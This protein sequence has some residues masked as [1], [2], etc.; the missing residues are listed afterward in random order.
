MNVRMKT[1]YELVVA[2]FGP[3]AIALAAAIEDAILEGRLPASFRKKVVFLEKAPRTEW[4]GGLLLPGT[5]IN[6]SEY[7]DLATPR[8]PGS[9]FTFAR[10]LKFFALL[11]SFTNSS[12]L[13]SSF[14]SRLA[15]RSRLD[16][17]CHGD[18][19]TPVCAWYG[20]YDDQSTPAA[21]ST[22]RKE[23][24]SASNLS[25]NS[26]S[27]LVFGTSLSILSSSTT[28]S[29]PVASLDDTA[30]LRP[31]LL[32]FEF[33][34]CDQSLGLGP[35]ALP[36][37]R[38]SGDLM[39]PALARPVPFWGQ[40]FLPPPLTS[41]RVFTLTVP[42]LQFA[43]CHTTTLCTMSCGG[44]RERERKRW[45]VTTTEGQVKLLGARGVQVQ[46]AVGRLTF[47]RGWS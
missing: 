45:W 17:H 14:S 46:A 35:W 15:D 11:S 42:C 25:R 27:S 6:H 18:F 29:L 44:A 1:P 4:Q 5:N 19:L 8:D 20:S 7:R 10:F 38:K 28:V 39:D 31:S 34:C 2:G 9:Q 26:R 32:I 41:D 21:S 43:L 13:D 22:R 16:R 24:L 47:R 37:P 23:V 12:H 33:S 40:G 36:P 30:T 3:A